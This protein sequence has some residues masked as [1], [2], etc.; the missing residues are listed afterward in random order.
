MRIRNRPI[1]VVGAATAGVL[2]ALA[3]PSPAAAATAPDKTV[4]I[5]SA[6]TDY[7]FSINA[8]YWSVIALQPQ[9][10]NDYDLSALTTGGGSSLGESIWGTGSTDFLAIDSNVGRQ[11]LASYK[12]TVVHYSGGGSYA[13]QFRMGQSVTALPTPAWD[14]VTGP[15]DPDITFVSL[16]D[17]DVASISD[18]R[19][20]AGEKFWVSSTNAGSHL[21]LL[22]SSD[23]RASWVQSRTEASRQNF[24][25][26]DGCTL[27]TAQAGGWHGLLMIGDRWPNAG[28]SGGI[29]YALHKYDPARPNTCPIRNFPGPTPA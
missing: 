17:A 8:T 23:D 20:A 18:I 28:S 22:E 11:P 27:Y 14:G 24:T 2:V 10:T 4:I 12:A 16:P 15:G 19:L 21:Y 29:G 5:S 26:V 3:N 13:V 7:T 1:W 9:A 6:P 25:F